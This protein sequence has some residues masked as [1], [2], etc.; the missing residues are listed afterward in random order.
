MVLSI[1]TFVGQECPTHTLRSVVFIAHGIF[2]VHDQNHQIK[3]KK[4]TRYFFARQ[5]SR[6]GILGHHGSS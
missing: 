4:G 2:V 6:A 5:L 1:Y 3:S